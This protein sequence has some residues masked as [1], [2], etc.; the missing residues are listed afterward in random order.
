MAKKK[1]LKLFVWKEALCD[2]TDGVMF[3]LAR[4]VDE[5]RQMLLEMH[6]DSSMV[7]ADISL[8]PDVYDS[9]FAFALW[10]G[11]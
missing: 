3:A 4:D 5:A 10:G 2:Y 8:D 1:K 11:G 7:R 6:P 9:P